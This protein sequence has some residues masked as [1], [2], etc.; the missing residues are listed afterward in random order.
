MSIISQNSGVGGGVGRWGNAKGI[1]VSSFKFI[2]GFLAAKSR[3]NVFDI[4][5]F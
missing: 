4:D 2:S 3:I 1:E 5:I